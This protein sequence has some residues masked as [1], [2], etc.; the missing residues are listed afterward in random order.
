MQRFTGNANCFIIQRHYRRFQRL[1][2]KPES[3]LI[4]WAVVSFIAFRHC[5][6]HCWR[7]R[8]E[9]TESDR[10]MRQNSPENGSINSQ[11]SRQTKQNKRSSC[12]PLW[13]DLHKW[14]PRWLTRFWSKILQKKAELSMHLWAFLIFLFQV[15]FIFSSSVQFNFIQTVSNSYVLSPQSCWTIWDDLKSRKQA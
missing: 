5:R 1:A 15:R 11:S 10:Q 3:R 12:E 4:S 13:R 2:G 8:A 14:Y 7:H 6:W 9:T